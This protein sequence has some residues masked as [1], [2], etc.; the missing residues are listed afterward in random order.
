[1]ARVLVV[2][3]DMATL[4]GFARVLTFD[5]HEVSTAHSGAEGLRIALDDRPEMVL[6]DLTLPDMT[7]LDFMRQ[8]R[9][10]GFSAPSIV[11]TGF[12]TIESA[13]TAIKMGAV[14]Y[15][16]K[17][18]RGDALTNAVRDA[19]ASSAGSR[20]GESCV[21][22]DGVRRWAAAVAAVVVSKRDPRNLADWS[23]IR[24][25]APDTL[26][27]WCRT[28][29]LLP[30]P[31]L[32]LAR[33]LRAVRLGRLQGWPPERLLDVA[34]RRTRQR[35]FTAAGLAPGDAAPTVDEVLVNQSL[36]TDP[37][38]IDELKNVLDEVIREHC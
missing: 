32:D 2:E 36:I 3:D 15:L 16:Q 5:G 14:D 35:L 6:I 30:K 24:G 8:L 29:S 21:R 17:P 34:D 13:V 25:V 1:M 38:A 19:L 18:L 31:S 37:L 28:A 12:G 20:V 4:D 9:T 33:I 10:L 27:T 11:V 7:A 22:A 26:R 23:R